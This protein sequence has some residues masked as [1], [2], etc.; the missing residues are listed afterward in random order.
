MLRHLFLALFLLKGIAPL[1]GQT[2]LF[3][4]RN[5]QKPYEKGTRSWDGKPGVN[6]WQNR[7]SYTI[8]G[9]LDP[10]TRRISGEETILYV[11]N[12]P[13]SLKSL[14]IKLQHDRYRK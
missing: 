14:R 2:T 11:N 13:D 9:V 12:S 5:Y 4:P 8:R 1:T 7:A 3:V 10:K 6:Y